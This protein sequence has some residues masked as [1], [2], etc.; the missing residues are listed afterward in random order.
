MVSGEADVEVEV[1]ARSRGEFPLILSFSFLDDS[2]YM[3][4]R[5]RTVPY[6]KKLQISVLLGIQD[7]TQTPNFVTAVQSSFAPIP[8]PNGGGGKPHGGAPK[9]VL[10]GLADTTS[11]AGL[12]KGIG[13]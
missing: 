9:R 1:V 10:K 8:H 5:S 3:G 7:L 13:S 2:T 4:I 12:N 11:L 6:D